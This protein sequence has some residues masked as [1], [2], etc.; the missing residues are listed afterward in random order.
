[1]LFPGGRM[2]FVR[3]RVR[4]IGGRI[5]RFGIFSLGC[6]RVRMFGRSAFKRHQSRR[7]QVGRQTPVRFA[8]D[9]FVGRAGFRSGQLRAQGSP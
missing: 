6:E 7:S 4:G 3:A 2:R 9:T 1:M 5:V 8:F